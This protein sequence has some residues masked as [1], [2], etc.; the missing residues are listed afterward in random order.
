MFFQTD[1]QSRY[2]KRQ[3][4]T[5]V[6]LVAVFLRAV[7][8]TCLLCVA[9]CSPKPSV[10]KW[11]EE[12][13]LPDQRVVE[14]TRE[15][16]FDERDLVSS[17]WFEFDHPDTG[18]SVKF[19]N[20]REFRTVALYSHEKHMHLVVR[21]TFATHFDNAGCPN[22]PYFL[23]RYEGKQWRQVPLMQSPL[24]HV[25]ENMTVDAKS[26]RAEIK[27]R[28]Y[29]IKADEV[30]PMNRGVG[31]AFDEFDLEKVKTQT[32]ACPDRKRYQLN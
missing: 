15:Q 25:S 17:Y 28:G 2:S 19:E 29:A 22:P 16:H 18:E 32:F 30:V 6:C 4:L 20:A 12:V 24:K 8:L 31:T 13:R 9:G 11:T 10:L 5:P 7:A 1:M 27:M 21:P 14:L 23:F 26:V 3:G